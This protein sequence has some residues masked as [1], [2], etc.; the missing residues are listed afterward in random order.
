MHDP[1]QPANIWGGVVAN[2]GTIQY[3]RGNAQSGW[4]ATASAGAVTGQR[5]R[6]N[7]EI[8]GDAG[9]Y[10][11]VWAKPTKS[12]KLGVNFYGQH[13]ARNE[14]FYTY[15]HGGYFSPEY[16]LLP[17][18]SLTLIGNHGSRL[19]YEFAGNLGPQIIQEA[20]APSFP[21]DDNLQSLRSNPIYPAQSTLGLNY[22]VQGKT[23][24]LFGEHWRLGAFFSANNADKYN[25]Q[26]AGISLH[27][28]FR[29]Q[30]P[31]TSVSAGW[32]PHSGLRPYLVP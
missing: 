8:T 14:L 4:Y 28:L 23:G 20:S 17:A 13:N 24:Y 15:G 3:A 22:G 27:Y 11:Q 6:T 2:L 21:L 32:F 18:I 29:G 1:A 25:Q 31:A 5:V 16:F 19:Q 7:P 10:R 30:R 26:V 12:L 9:A